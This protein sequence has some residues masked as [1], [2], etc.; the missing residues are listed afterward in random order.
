[1]RGSGNITDYLSWAG[2]DG[3]IVDYGKTK[4]IV[5]FDTSKIKIINKEKTSDFYSSKQN[6][7]EGS[8]QDFEFDLVK[9]HIQ[10]TINNNGLGFI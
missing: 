10:K 2:Y 7:Q 8:V 1:M 5:V 3:V 6:L 9:N 4:E